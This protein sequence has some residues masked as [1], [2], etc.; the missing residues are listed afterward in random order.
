MTSASEWNA[1]YSATKFWSGKPNSTLVSVAQELDAGKA[2]DLGCGEG[3]DAVWL[4]RHGWRV[5]GVDFSGNALAHADS[6]SE[7]QGVAA[8]C[9]WVQADLSVWTTNRSYDLVTCHYLHE[10]LEVRERAWRSAAA[11]VG[12][13]GTLLV[14][15]HAPDE[16]SEHHDPTQEDLFCGDQ[17]LQALGLDSHWDVDIT[18]VAR[19]PSNDARHSDQDVVLRAKRIDA[20]RT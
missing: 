7:E 19:E 2:L 8:R 6:A 12:P 3:G 18:T 1:R 14:V 11:A 20:R 9:E 15:G 4:A 10:A 17:V 5:R 16:S 13:G